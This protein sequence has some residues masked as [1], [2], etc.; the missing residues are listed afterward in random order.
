M[1][2]LSDEVGVSDDESIDAEEDSVMLRLN[3]FLVA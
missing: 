2:L 1:E 3:R